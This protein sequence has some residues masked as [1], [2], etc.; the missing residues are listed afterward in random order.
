MKEVYNI[1]YGSVLKIFGWLM[2]LESLLLILPALV[3]LIYGEEDWRAFLVSII[4]TGAIGGIAAYCFRDNETHVHRREG[5]LLISFVWVLF[6]AFGMLPFILGSPRLGVADAF[7][8]TV[9]GFTTT[10]A[11]V[12]TDVESQ[13]HG[14]LFWRSV[15]QWIGGLGIVFFL[16]ALLPALNDSGGISLFNAEITG[17]THDKLHPRIRKTAMSLWAVYG[18]LTLLMI[19]LL[20]VGGMSVFDSICQAMTTMS[21]GGFST[22]NASIA[23]WESPWIAGVVTVFMFVGGVNF[24]LVYNAVSGQWRQL[25]G[26]GV[27]RNYL[28]IVAA[29]FILIAGSLLAVPGHGSYGE[30]TLAALFQISSSITSTG[31]TYS[32]FA[33]WGTLPLMIIILLMMC[34][35]CAGSTTG[36]IKVD[37]V[38]VLF[39]NIRN[40]IVLTLFPRHIKMVEFGKGVLSDS[41]L[42]RVMAFITIYILIVIAGALVMSGYGYTVTDSFFASASCMGNNGL[43]FG[44]TGAGYGELP[45]PLMWLF[46]LEMLVGRLEIFTVL[47]LFYTPFWRK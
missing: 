33:A 14:I 39:K 21:T 30:V 42:I 4:S 2:L 24:I 8:E 25:W 32:N 10:G 5:Y 3:C 27:F 28:V 41:A 38:A 23:S 35:A 22:R 43:G 7:F 9:S 40:E 20:A 19:P 17:V 37:R 12:M 45:D 46:S 34:G 6:S 44:A 16:I 13:S 11:T 36:G 47:V 15:I 26:N 1:R 18:G 29:A 31:L